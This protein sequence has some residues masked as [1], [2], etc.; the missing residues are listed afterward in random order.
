MH[1]DVVSALDAPARELPAR[2]TLLLLLLLL[3]RYA[4]MAFLY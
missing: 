4:V 2:C 3:L 1:S